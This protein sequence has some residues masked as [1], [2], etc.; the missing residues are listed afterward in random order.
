MQCIDEIASLAPFSAM[1]P[2]GFVLVV[3]LI[4]EAFDDIVHFLFGFY[5]SFRKGTKMTRKLIYN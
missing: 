1:T 3:S 2:L 5:I 4:R